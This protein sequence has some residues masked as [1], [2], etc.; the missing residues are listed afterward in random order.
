[1]R[2]ALAVLAIVVVGLLGW[3]LWPRAEPS[4]T[5][6]A[7]PIASAKPTASAVPFAPRPDN[8]PEQ[9]TPTA[10]TSTRAGQVVF[11]MVHDPAGAPLSGVSVR[12]LPKRGAEALVVHTGAQGEYIIFAVQSPVE[13]LE[14][15][16]TGFQ[17]LTFEKPSF[18][19]SN[20][21][22]WDATLEPARGVYGMVV[23]QGQP[24]MGAEVILRKPGMRHPPMARSRSDGE[25]RFALD[26]SGETSG[27]E[28]VAWH[29]QYGEGATR[30]EGTGAVTVE[31]P[32]GGF[33]E[34]NV[35]DSEGH[36]ITAF[37]VD[38]SGM[39][40][41]SVDDDRGHYRL[42]PIAGGPHRLVAVAPGYRPTESKAIE[43]VVGQTI[44]D[45][46]FVL[47]KSA[48][49]R[50]RVTDALTKK[51][52]AGAEITPWEVG[53]DEL[54]ASVGT[55]TGDDGRY[56]LS[57]V[58]GK[59]STIRA[60]AKGYRTLM[61]G[62]VN[63]SSTKPLTLDFALTPIA[64]NERP[65]NE[66][67]GI[68]ATLSQVGN[69]VVVNGL[70]PG[71]AAEGKLHQGDV[72]VMVNDLKTVGTDLS[73]IVQAIR[74]ELGSDVT[75]WVLRGGQGDPERISLQRGRVSF[76]AGP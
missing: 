1:M 71:G 12:I 25:G 30:V 33:V 39:D 52:I 67:I 64:P 40:A 20:R 5:T 61:H 50:G 14:F 76:P 73:E 24:V 23:S 75:L 9:P 13:R 28:V 43:I 57:S 51:P 32:G 4:S 7:A 54:E 34:G 38:A 49:V 2:R 15:S 21:V 18:P 66:L 42:G 16:A 48:E 19:S 68:G 60:A 10:A 58:P 29:G 41:V 74:G 35:K 47:Q 55:F 3:W 45:I 27:M 70:L 22:R 37:T 31:L 69:G 6:E 11:G 26:F 59:R 46:D 63:G 72:I 53:S 17:P 8:L 36:A 44:S 62:G 56:V 65:Q